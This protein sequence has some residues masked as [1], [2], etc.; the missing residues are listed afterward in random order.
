VQYLGALA[1][2]VQDVLVARDDAGGGRLLA[3][4]V[5]VDAG[6]ELGEL[7]CSGAGG[8][9]AVLVAAELGEHDLEVPAGLVLGDL[10]EELALGTA[11]PG[12]VAFG[13]R[14]AHVL[15]GDLGGE[16]PA[17]PV[18]QFAGQGAAQHPRGDGAVRDRGE[19]K[20]LACGAVDPGPEPVV[21]RLEVEPAEYQVSGDAAEAAELLGH[22]DGVMDGLDDGPFLAGAAERLPLDELALQ[23]A[24]GQAVAVAGDAAAAAAQLHQLALAH[25]CQGGG[26]QEACGVGVAGEVADV[27]LV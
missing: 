8:H 2:Q 13:G 17:W 27:A 1:E 19:A 6:E 23:P 10:G 14:D 3:C 26:E 22:A 7:A 12:C 5:R 20:A 16:Q 25:A 21:A 11:G 4:Q 18:G 9:D 15:E 24:A